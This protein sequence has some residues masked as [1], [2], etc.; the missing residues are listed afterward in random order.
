MWKYTIE[1]GDGAQLEIP[2]LNALG[3]LAWLIGYLR[4]EETMTVLPPVN[5]PLNITFIKLERVR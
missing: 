3:V 1:Y 2:N 4:A 5:S